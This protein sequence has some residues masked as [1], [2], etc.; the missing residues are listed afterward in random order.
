MIRLTALTLIRGT[1][2]LLQAAD[3]T[4]NPGEKVGLIGANGSGKS[5][6]FALLRNELQPDAGDAFFPASNMPS[7]ATRIC[8]VWKPNW[9]TPKPAMTDTVSATCMP[10]WP[11]RMP[12]PCAHAAN[13]CSP[14]WGFRMTR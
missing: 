5:S 3:L 11:M 4:L 8:A 6:L 12:T 2:P 10:R 1:K 14:A 13:N 9:K 7:M